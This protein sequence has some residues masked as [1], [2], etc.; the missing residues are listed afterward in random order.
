MRYVP[1][2][3]RK[4]VQEMDKNL[5]F[6]TG[7]SGAIGRSL[8]EHLIAEKCRVRALAH[9][10]PLPYKEIEQVQGDIREFRAEWLDGVTTLIHL[11]AITR[12]MWRRSYPERDADG[13]KA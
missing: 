10:S 13:T 3:G 1:A 2:G 5:Y 8:I 7:G 11:A 9:A 6:V 12:P 4:G